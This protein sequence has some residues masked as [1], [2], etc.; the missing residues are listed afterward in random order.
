MPARQSDPPEEDLTGVPFPPPQNRVV[1]DLDG[2]QLLGSPPSIFD[3]YDDIAGVDDFVVY[4]DERGQVLMTEAFVKEGLTYGYV[5]WTVDGATHSTSSPASNELAMCVADV[6]AVSMDRFD[7]ELVAR[8]VI[9]SDEEGPQG[10][11][12][13]LYVECGGTQELL[14]S[15]IDDMRLNRTTLLDVTCVEVTVATEEHLRI[16]SNSR[17]ESLDDFVD[18]VGPCF[19]WSVIPFA[20]EATSSL[21]LESRTVDGLRSIITDD[22]PGFA[23]ILESCLTPE[24]LAQIPN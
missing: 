22:S 3:L 23:A 5:T 24:E 20:L 15:F 17:E 10:E 21:C 6:L 7:A 1:W 2:P 11:L 9:E 4:E 13:D 16:V 19:N 18:L 14:T 12:F 8:G